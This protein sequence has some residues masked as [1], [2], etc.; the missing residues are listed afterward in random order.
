MASFAS[1]L[2]SGGRNP[3]AI[4]ADRLRA[5]R[6][7]GPSPDEV[8]AVFPEFSAARRACTDPD[9]TVAAPVLT[10]DRPEGSRRDPQGER[11][12][13]EVGARFTPR[14]PPRP[15]VLGPEQ[16]P[17][18]ERRGSPLRLNAPA[19]PRRRV[20]ARRDLAGR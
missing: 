20:G 6:L 10:H 2:H 7:H 12:H 5:D 17:G 19:R 1:S 3:D 16:D 11:H 15:A 9:G 14:Q 4:G 13:V 8:G 18:R